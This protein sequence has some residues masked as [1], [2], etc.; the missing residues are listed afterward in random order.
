LPACP[1]STRGQ[2]QGV[3]CGFGTEISPTSGETSS[4]WICTSAIGVGAADAK[5]P[6]VCGP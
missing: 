6:P 3:S 1:R 2:R 4:T 5:K